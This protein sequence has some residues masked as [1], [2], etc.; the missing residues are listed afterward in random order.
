MEQPAINETVVRRYL[1]GQL[2]E[3]ERERLEVGL[4]TDDRVFDTLTAL[5]D[6]VEDEL[7][8]QYLDGELTEAEREKFESVFLTTP[9]RTYKL[10]LIKDLKHHVA[11]PVYEEVPVGKIAATNVTHATWI[12]AIGVFQN[13]LFGLSAATALTLAL[14]A[15]AWLWIRANNLETQLRQAQ[16]DHPT[17][18]ALKQ[19]VEHLRQRNEELTANLQ[20]SEEQR[21]TLEQDL[22]ALKSGQGP[23]NKTSPPRPTFATVVLSPSLRSTDQTVKNL[24]IP[25]GVPKAQLILKI[26]RIDPKDYKNFR[27]VVKKQA[28]AEISRNDNL[29]LQPSG[30]NARAILMIPAEKLA[31]GRYI[32]EVEGVTTD[33]QSEL[34]G[35]YLFQVI[36]SNSSQFRAQP[37]GSPDA[38]A[39]FKK[40]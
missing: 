39:S 5:E 3:E 31:D 30:N 4:L 17:D 15:C 28:G 40:N 32:V 23:G 13:P 21:T 19:Q 24:S 27:A 11:V 29:K 8:D 10:K 26:E 34:V 12:P 20:R 22:A 1:L 37:A 36:H 25:A 16:A 9:E 38:F 18:A 2:P 33:G 35:L 14:V 6:E 7:I